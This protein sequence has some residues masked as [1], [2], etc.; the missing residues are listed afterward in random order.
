MDAK[1][2]VI[3][4]S[5]GRLSPKSTTSQ[6]DVARIVKTALDT[7]A[8][9]G[10]VVHFH[11]GLVSQSTARAAAASALYP[12]YAEESKAYPIFFVWESGFFEA[13][14]NNLREIAREPLFREFV[15]KAAEW[16]LKK[17]PAGVGFKG[18]SG[19]S[20]DEPKLRADFDAWFNGQR[21]SP[22][23]Q[24]EK[25][26]GATNASVAIKSRAGTLDEDELLAEIDESIEGDQ[27]FQNAVQAVYNGL[28]SGG[29]PRPT[30]RGVGTSIST[31]SLISKEAAEEMFPAA[32]GT[33]KGFGPIT[34]LRIAKVVAMVVIRVIRRL[35][36]G[37]AHGGY[38]TV[39]EETLRQVYVDKIGRTVWWDRMKTDTAD[40]FKEG[41]EYG[42][43]AFLTELE[44]QLKSRD[45]HPKITLIG[46]STGAIYICNFLKAAAQLA[47]DLKFDVI[48]EAPAA[49][50]S[51]LAATAAEHASRIRNF[52]QFGM[53]DQ[54]EAGDV[55][56]P[57][58][59]I[60]SLL[61]FVSGLL[62][63][64]PDEPLVGM[65]RYQVDTTIYDAES[66]PS[67]EA[68]RR[69]YDRYPNSLVWSPS[70]SGPGLNCD[71]KSHGAF[72]DVDQ[73]T[74]DSIKHILMHGF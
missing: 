57:I 18:G 31:T 30:T 43:T 20:V 63:G 10:I 61:Y 2:H 8:P 62:E 5:D 66:F 70:T 54:R 47:P 36:K 12:L 33:T 39:V 72:D 16:V 21:A 28:H 19:A 14:L 27:D 50:H 40:A 42:G 59:Y 17:L 24:L 67:V 53:S 73:A 4:L 35:R 41:P 7:N 15:K 3:H 29:T 44:T 32:S 58:I 46:H 69:F 37:R 52:R 11:G 56:V 13:P 25:Q 38:V 45:V 48:F 51:L 60:S 49:R 26:P 9:S 64:E 68:C 6:H 65:Q 34:W 1:N 74:M 55:L 71:G 22:P 23:E